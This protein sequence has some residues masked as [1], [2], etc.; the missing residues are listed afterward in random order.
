LNTI[1]AVTPP[2]DVYDLAPRI[3]CVDLSQDQS[4]IVSNSLK[5]VDKD[6][7]VYIWTASQD[8]VWLFDKAHKS[9]LVITNA[10]TVHQDILGWLCAFK[11]C[12]YFGELK[13]LK[14]INKNAIYSEH[15]L[16]RYIKDLDS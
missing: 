10:D 1:T 6:C 2:D 7:I 13:N 4:Q 14:N 3:L 11:N 16:I 8:A 12:F 15:D 9:S 5:N